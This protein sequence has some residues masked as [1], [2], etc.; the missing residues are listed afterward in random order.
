MRGTSRYVGLG[1]KP[2]FTK[3][4]AKMS[5]RR[6]GL[7]RGSALI[8]EKRSRHRSLKSPTARS[9]FETARG[10]GKGLR[11]DVSPAGRARVAAV[12][13]PLLD[14]ILIPASANEAAVRVGSAPNRPIDC[15]ATRTPI[16]EDGD[17]HQRGGDHCGAPRDA[18]GGHQCP[19][20][21]AVAVAQFVGGSLVRKKGR[22]YCR[23]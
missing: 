6:T 15:S 10:D 5:R 21:A 3:R 20:A 17:H 19:A 2:T 12:A 22:R 16:P 11:S 13:G 9:R 1:H 23:P 14:A 4:V 7:Q 8:E 18:I